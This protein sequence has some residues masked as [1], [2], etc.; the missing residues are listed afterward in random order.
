MARRALGALSCKIVGPSQGKKKKDEE[1]AGKPA[2]SYYETSG[3]LRLKTPSGRTELLYDSQFKYLKL[4]STVVKVGSVASVTASL[5]HH[6][7]WPA[8]VCAAVTLGPWSRVW[9]GSL[10]MEA[11]RPSAHGLHGHDDFLP[12]VPLKYGPTTSSS[13][14]ITRKT[15]GERGMTCKVVRGSSGSGH[16]SHSANTQRWGKIVKVVPRG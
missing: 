3:P 16:T 14:S 15:T 8:M 6:Q 11:K 9:C 1:A 10:D 2:S 7:G 5:R 12:D 4:E 13:S